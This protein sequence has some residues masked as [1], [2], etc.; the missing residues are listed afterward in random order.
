M[1][2]R[3]LLI[4]STASYRAGAFL[5][6]AAGLG[7]ETVVASDRPQALAGLNPAGH[8]TLDFR[9]P[10]GAARAITDFARVHPLDAVIG[11]DDDSVPIAAHAARD[12]GLR[13]H[14]PEAVRIARHKRLTRERLDAAGIL[15]PHFAAVEV[16]QGASAAAAVAAHVGLPCVLKPVALSASRGVLR[17]DDETGA[18]AAFERIRALLARADAIAMGPEAAGEILI[19]EYVPGDEVA[20]EG[21]VTRGEFR[22]LATFDKPDPLT[23]PTFEETLYVTPSRLQ[24][25]ACEQVVETTRAAIEAIGL[26]DG[27]VHAEL[28]VNARGAWPLEIAPRSI[29]GLC[30]RALRF[31]DGGSLERLLLMHAL[32]RDVTHLGREA[33]ASGVMMVPIPGAGRLERI[34]GLEEARTVEGIESVR[35]TVPAGQMIEPLPE[36]SRYLGFIFARAAAPEQVEAALR[37]A[38][39]RLRITIAPLEV[40]ANR[41]GMERS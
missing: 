40:A 3:L 16:G 27:P 4:V 20:V 30:S 5:E 18:R 6:A 10:A 25:T 9:D 1:D 41:T 23:G 35:I 32:G 12:L 2:Q 24:G 39:A 34:E 15:Q 31:E 36:G 26:A 19:E 13:H 29:G 21:L 14:S 17:A 38:H 33:Q 8:L 11:A 22:V 28:R 37:A 7:L